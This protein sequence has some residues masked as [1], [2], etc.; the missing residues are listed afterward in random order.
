ML[1][2]PICQRTYCFCLRGYCDEIEIGCGDL[3]LRGAKCY[4]SARH[5]QAFHARKPVL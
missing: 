1:Q 2:S 4:S 3:R 5:A